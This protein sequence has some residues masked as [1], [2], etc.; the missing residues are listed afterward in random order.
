MT[1]SIASRST[2][3]R[4]VAVLF[5][6]AALSS[7]VL[8]APT[9]SPMI[10]SSIGVRDLQS[11]SSS[12]GQGTLSEGRIRELTMIQP[13][14]SRHNGDG[15]AID[16]SAHGRMIPSWFGARD[17]QPQ[18]SS[19]GLGTLSEGQNEELARVP[20]PQRG[21]KNGHGP[22]IDDLEHGRSDPGNVLLSVKLKQQVNIAERGNQLSREER[23][24]EER[25][26]QAEERQ[27][28]A[29]ERQRQARERQRQARERQRQAEARRKDRAEQQ[30]IK[31][32]IRAE[33]ETNQRY[34]NDFSEEWFQAVLNNDRT[35]RLKLLTDK[36]PGSEVPNHV[37]IKNLRDTLKS[38]EN[39]PEFVQL[40]RLARNK[41]VI[42][43]MWMKEQVAAALAKWNEIHPQ[44]DAICSG[45]Q[46]D[47]VSE[48]N[49]RNFFRTHSEEV[50]WM[51][52]LSEVAL[53]M[54]CCDQ[55]TYEAYSDF[56][57]EVQHAPH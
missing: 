3:S 4:A 47:E 8:A 54:Q 45:D 30:E 14:V 10:P 56:W 9:R 23:Q 28:Q 38:V 33:K 36:V 42:S 41:W 24:A 12:D 18:S 57:W 5:L 35:K 48:A 22:T 16:N 15:L 53:G 46:P 50:K 39:D 49:R 55:Q 21:G 11:Q 1:R 44:W 13:S 34:L 27:R 26:R 52:D 31:N 32:R 29:R 17:L 40:W 19:D 51:A 20:T 7:G 37:R 43:V 25:Q 2:A 6:G